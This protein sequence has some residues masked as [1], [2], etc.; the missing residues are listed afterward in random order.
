MTPDEVKA[1]IAAFAGD[2]QSP[3]TLRRQAL[4]LSREFGDY[5]L[6]VGIGQVADGSFIPDAIGYKYQQFFTHW[7]V[8]ALTRLADS[9]PKSTCIQQFLKCLRGLREQGEMR[10][11]RWVERIAGVS[12]WREAR[13][14]EKRKSEKRLAAAGGGSI[15]SPIG[16]GETAAMLNEI[17][18]RLTG[19]KKGSDDPK[20]DMEDWIFDSCKQ[21]LDHPSMKAV[22]AWRNKTVAHQDLSRTRNGVAA[23]DVFPHQ[24]LI[25]AYWAV[26][27]STH[28]A[29]L[30]AEE[31]GLPNLYPTPQFD[32][33]GELSGGCLDS[34]ETNALNERLHSHSIRW[35]CLLQQSEHQWYRQLRKL[36]YKEKTGN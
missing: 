9:N 18:N 2:E 30:L 11:D 24:T 8:S 13:D 25:R 4:D 36:R 34:V 14:I 35:D 31:P 5:G 15:W 16:P 6:A 28:R 12:G 32:I 3:G 19:R 23:Y 21:P 26:M 7:A 10:R 33:V 27:K 22:R 17:Y 20:D 29:L 1:K